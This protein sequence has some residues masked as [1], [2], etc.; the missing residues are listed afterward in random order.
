LALQSSNN[1]D[2][3]PTLELFEDEPVEWP[4]PR[5]RR[6]PI[7]ARLILLVLAGIWLTVFVLAALLNPYNPD[8]T[9][10][11]MGTHRGPPLNLPDCTFK[12]F[13]GMPCPS[14]GMTTSF[15]LLIHGDVWNSLR[16]N[17]AG[18]AL[19][20]LGLFFLPWSF[21]SAWRGRLLF[22]S[23]VEMTL[24]R[25]SLAFIVLLFSHWAIAIALTF[26]PSAGG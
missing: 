13:T 23:S 14:C 16:A 22:I 1:D 21:A 18:T 10:K 25:L 12:E 11:T 4:L 15:S 2:I 9:P 7:W 6:L 24:F 3:V 5:R 17:F 8:G 20:S 26:W 19:A